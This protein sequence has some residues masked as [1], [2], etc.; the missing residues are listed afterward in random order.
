MNWL[1]STRSR[2]LIL[3]ASLLALLGVLDSIARSFTEFDGIGFAVTLW[4]CFAAVY[5]W[6]LLEPMIDSA[7]LIKKIEKAPEMTRLIRLA[8]DIAARTG[9]RVPNFVMYSD[10]RFNVV[11]VGIGRHQTIIISDHAASLPDAQ[12]GAII[13]HE[14]GHIQLKHPVMR[15]ALYGSLLALAMIANGTPLLALSANL[16]V[17][18]S[19]RQMEFAADAQAARTVGKPAMHGALESV[20]EMMGGD[21]PVWQ[22]AFNTHPTFLA[23]TRRLI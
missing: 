12:L 20:C 7:L 9:M 14:Y 19:M 15:L 21:M 8:N 2:Y 3:G 16:F 5:G 11:T 18:W 22:T 1:P 13:A 6:L 23:R 10:T 4:S 17:L